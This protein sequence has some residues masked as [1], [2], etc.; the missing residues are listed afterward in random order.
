MT[1]LQHFHTAS[2]L[3]NGINFH[4]VLCIVAL[5]R[6]SSYIKFILMCLCIFRSK[7]EYRNILF[8]FKSLLS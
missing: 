1:E 2:H 4:Y 8:R 3:L 6:N 7:F 5:L